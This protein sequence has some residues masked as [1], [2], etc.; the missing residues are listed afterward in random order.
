MQADWSTLLA[1]AAAGAC[2]TAFFAGTEIG[3]TSLDP[4][5][6]RS[7]AAAP[8]RRLLQR[9]LARRRGFIITT[10]LGNNLFLVGT[11]VVMT[12]LAAERWGERSAL[13]VTALLTL[14]IFLF[15]EMLPKAFF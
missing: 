2:G 7:D 15:G 6:I 1:V 5:R 12:S 9:L 11:S 3:L 13:P 10:I 4:L 14:F 8:G